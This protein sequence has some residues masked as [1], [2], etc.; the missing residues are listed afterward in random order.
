MKKTVIVY[1]L[2]YI[3]FFKENIRYPV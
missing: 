2:L 1:L 3:I